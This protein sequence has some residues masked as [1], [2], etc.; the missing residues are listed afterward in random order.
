MTTLASTETQ[1]LYRVDEIGAKIY[2]VR[3]ATAATIFG[4]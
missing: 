1:L 2:E 3:E 4:Q